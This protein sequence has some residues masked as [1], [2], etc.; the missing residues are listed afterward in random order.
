MAPI[1]IKHVVSCS[2]ED[3][4]HKADNLLRDDMYR[5]WKSASPGQRS[6][7]VILQFEKASEIHSID[8]GNEGSAFIE[9]LVGKSASESDMQVILVS[10]SFMSPVESKNNTNLNRVRMFGPDKLSKT[11][12]D[13]KWDR[14]KIVC[15]QPFNK[16][17]TYG[18]SFI[19]FHSSSSAAN[20]AAG[21]ESSKKIGA[22][23]L[24]DEPSPKF[25]PGSL[26]KAEKVKKVDES[27]PLK[28]AAAVRA[29]THTPSTS[30]QVSTPQPSNKRR[31]SNED[32]KPKGASPLSR[33]TTHTPTSTHREKE[34]PPPMKRTKSEPSKTPKKFSELMNGVVFALSGFQNPTRANIRDK[35][36]SMGAKYKPDWGNDCTHL[37]CA[38][39]NTPKFIQVKK[40]GGKIVTAKWV[41]DCH[42]KKMLFPW[43]KYQLGDPDS[44]SSTEESDIEDTPK[45]ETL[46]KK[47]AKPSPAKPTEMKRKTS[48]SPSTSQKQKEEEDMYGGSTDEEMGL[49]VKGHAGA[50]EGSSGSDTEDEIERVRQQTKQKKTEEN[51]DIYGGS[52]DEESDVPQLPDF[53]SKLCFFLYGNFAAKERRLLTRLI[54]AYNGS[55]EEYMDD[56]VQYVVTNSNWDDNFNQAL[57]DNSSLVFVKPKW[58]YNCDESQKRV[59]YQPY[60]VVP[61]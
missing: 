21:V 28:G 3:Q 20:A 43:R 61:K 1:T 34:Q 33:K 57:S 41:Q 16:H 47:Q 44:G 53:Y 7:S 12:K 29:A 11:V 40:K 4:A 27:T 59:P 55:I 52:T 49:E 60:V 24:R 6:I 42:K 56:N 38:F 22:F 30:T 31:L 39:A 10:S 46:Q 15:S 2:N 9:V 5:K 8:I 26:F 13:Q 19:K 51:D 25:S 17:I 18:L 23:K 54:V 36:V 50:S 37:I 48:T 32:A 58:V 35:A 14:V 45:K